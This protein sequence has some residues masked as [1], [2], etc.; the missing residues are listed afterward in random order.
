MPLVSEKTPR[1]RN[2]IGLVMLVAILGAVILTA[3][4]VFNQSTAIDATKESVA[5]TDCA[6]RVNAEQTGVRD[7]ATLADRA[8]RRYLDNV[9][10]EQA[11]TGMRPTVE[12]QQQRAPEFRALIDAAVKADDAVKALPDPA[13]EVERRCPG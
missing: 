6:R 9:L 12:Q 1:W 10:Y 2:I 8:A 5:R 4:V 3:V 7:A 13:K 11:T